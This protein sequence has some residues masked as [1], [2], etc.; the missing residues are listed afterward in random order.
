MNNYMN[1]DELALEYQVIKLTQKER[2]LKVEGRYFGQSPYVERARRCILED[3][4]STLME[5]YNTSQAMTLSELDKMRKMY[6]LCR[7]PT[8]GKT[9]YYIAK[10]SMDVEGFN[11]MFRRPFCE[12]IGKNFFDKIFNTGHFARFMDM[13]EQSIFLLSDQLLDLKWKGQWGGIEGLA[14][15]I[16]TWIYETVASKVAEGLGY[17]FQLL[18]NGD[19]SDDLRVILFIPTHSVEKEDLP[20]LLRN[21]AI[22]FKQEY[23]SFGFSLKLEESYYSLSMLGFS[24]MYMVDKHWYS[25]TLKKGAKLHGLAN[26][27]GDLPLEYLKG[28]MSETVSCCSYS[29]NH[30]YIFLVGLI[31]F[32]RCLYK[33]V[34]SQLSDLTDDQLAFLF[35]FPSCFGGLPVLPYIRCLAK[36]DSD[37]ETIWLSI[38]K[39]IDSQRVSNLPQFIKNVLTVVFKKSHDYSGLA[40]NS[41]SIPLKTPTDGLSFLKSFIKEAIHSCIRNRE[42]KE[43]MKMARPRETKQFI[44]SLFDCNPCPAK[45]LSVLYE[46]S[47]A[48]LLDEFCNKFTSARSIAE[49]IRAETSARHALKTIRSAF[50]KDVR[51]IKMSIELMLKETKFGECKM[52]FEFFKQNECPTKCSDLIREYCWQKEIIGVTYPCFIDQY[53]IVKPAM[54]ISLHPPTQH[55]TPIVM[56]IHSTEGTV[57]LCYSHGNEPMSFGSLTGLKISPPSIQLRG[58]SPGMSRVRKLL[59]LHPMF[60]RLGEQIQ[61]Y[62]LNSLKTLTGLNAD[63]LLSAE[64][65]VASGTITHRVPANHWSPLVGPNELPNRT[66]YCQGSTTT[67]TI[68]LSRPGDWTINYN[69]N[70]TIEMCIA[71]YRTEFNAWQRIVRPE[72]FQFY[73]TDCSSCISE[74]SDKVIWVA[75]PPD[76]FQGLH[77]NIY[78][79]FSPEDR[80]R[81]EADLTLQIAIERTQN[82]KILTGSDIDLLYAQRAVCRAIVHS[83]RSVFN[84]P[85]NSAKIYNAFSDE[86]NHTLRLLN[87]KR[88]I[89]LTE[90][91]HSLPKLLDPELYLT[92]KD[93]AYEHM[94]QYIYHDQLSLISS[95][96]RSTLP[97]IEISKAM[98][99]CGYWPTFRNYLVSTYGDSIPYGSTASAEDISYTLVVI[100]ARKFRRD[101]KLPDTLVELSVLSYPNNDELL[102]YIR[103]KLRVEAWSIIHYWLNSEAVRTFRNLLID[104]QYGVCHDFL[105]SIFFLHITEF[106]ISLRDQPFPIF[107]THQKDSRFFVPILLSLGVPLDSIRKLRA[108][109]TRTYSNLNT[110]AFGTQITYYENQPY[111]KFLFSFQ[112]KN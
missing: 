72:V 70:K 100:Y 98:I 110:Q 35:L 109:I 17:D 107:T 21:I 112:A 40:T 41:F 58:V 38:W 51:R 66:T 28:I 92:F 54:G 32:G 80:A 23:G 31:N 12:P 102:N 67:D 78:V 108:R 22:N 3:N 59:Q 45:A 96:H 30:R 71:L 10:F 86:D 43:V 53:L 97:F 85:S 47:P 111:L 18:V 64:W 75:N 4:I 91:K 77:D 84:D 15:K 57:N 106:T 49:L 8:K 1:S 81:L 2:E 14:Q 65:K 99:E 50:W 33:Y 82:F 79:G 87:I 20:Q 60:S 56:N 62:C 48:G 93:W 6:I 36:G 37:L 69:Y 16:W 74:V 83:F 94:A 52:P 63:L 46:T 76:F 42:F 24:K 73:E 55:L 95:R 29:T 104:H 44:A 27:L 89:G 90:I 13:F 39:F 11:N 88:G 7:G 103:I 68:A 19:E 101:N 25:T 9:D 61:N 34:Q 5:K 26:L 105:A